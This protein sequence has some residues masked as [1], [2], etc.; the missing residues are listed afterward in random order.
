MHEPPNAAFSFDY[1]L[2]A[3]PRFLSLSKFNR[4]KRSM[5][6][7]HALKKKSLSQNSLNIWSAI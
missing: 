3:L 4:N 2:I 7:K 5:D 6:L 1:I